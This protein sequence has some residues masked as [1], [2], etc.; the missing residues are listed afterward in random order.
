MH[1]TLFGGIIL[2]L[3][4][5]SLFVYAQSYVADIQNN[6]NVST[7]DKEIVKFIPTLL[8]VFIFILAGMLIYSALKRGH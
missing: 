6:L 4:C 8:I 2:I 1:A 5:L 7:T 3:L